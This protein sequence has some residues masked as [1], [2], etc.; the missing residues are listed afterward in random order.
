MHSKGFSLSWRYDK[1]PTTGSASSRSRSCS[2]FLI[3]FSRDKISR[4]I[5]SCRLCLI[6]RTCG[7]LYHVKN[8]DSIYLS[9]CFWNLTLREY[10][11]QLL[12]E[13]YEVRRLKCMFIYFFFNQL[14]TLI[15]VQ[16]AKLE[17]RL[18]W[19]FSD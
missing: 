14:N 2:C 19:S 15:D 13:N 3:L 9:V 10:I 12:H 7:I 4:Y 8:W 18:Y 5:V 1:G 17:Y 16:L 11:A 6:S